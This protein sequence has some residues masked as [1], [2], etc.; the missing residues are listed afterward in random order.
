LKKQNN[1]FIF[2]FKLIFFI[3]LNHFNR[4]KTSKILPARLQAEEDSCS[5]I[6][7]PIQLSESEGLGKSNAGS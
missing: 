6:E 3:I 7:S 5:V 2:Y 4:L 1:L